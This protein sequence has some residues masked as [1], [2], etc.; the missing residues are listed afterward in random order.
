MTLDPRRNNRL[1]VLVSLLLFSY[2][3]YAAFF[4]FPWQPSMAALHK[5]TVAQVESPLSILT[6]RH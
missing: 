5:A 4:V 1:T 6:D 3:Q 2:R